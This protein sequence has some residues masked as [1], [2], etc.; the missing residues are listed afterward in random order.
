MNANTLLPVGDNF[1][2]K[3][4]E[5]GAAAAHLDGDVAQGS[6]LELETGR[7]S[8][9]RTADHF[10]LARGV[11]FKFLYRHP[12]SILAWECFFTAWDNLGNPSPVVRHM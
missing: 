1:V 4:Q 9:I 3:I 8:M 2:R 12:Q 6:A 5:L 7:L 10:Q 11:R